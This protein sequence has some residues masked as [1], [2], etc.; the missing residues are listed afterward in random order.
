MNERIVTVEGGSPNILKYFNIRSFLF[1][2]AKFSK[3][4]FFMIVQKQIYEKCPFG[5]RDAKTH[6]DLWTG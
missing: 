1:S 3:V 5:R 6:G 4:L 2:N